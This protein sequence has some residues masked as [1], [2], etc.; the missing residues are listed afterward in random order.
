MALP[1]H[2]EV[3]GPELSS[4]TFLRSAGRL[5]YFALFI[6]KMKKVM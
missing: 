4:M 3:S 6:A 5:S 1:A 2:F